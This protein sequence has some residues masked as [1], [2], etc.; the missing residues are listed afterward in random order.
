MADFAA[1]LE[2]VNALAEAAPGFVWRYADASGAA[3]DT[4]AFD[5]PLILVNVSMW[6]SIEAFRQF[7]YRGEHLEFFR[8]RAEWFTRPDTPHLAM[9]WVPA[10]HRP[11]P[12][13]A[14]QRLEHLAT[15]GES[16]AAFTFTRPFPPPVHVAET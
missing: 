8:R 12:F 10:G 9:W 11:T 7:V 6:E 14:R 16:E 3:V 1:A 4:Q 15:H 5:D 13:E 2:R